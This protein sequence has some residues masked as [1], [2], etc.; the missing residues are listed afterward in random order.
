MKQPIVTIKGVTGAL[1]FVKT[2]DFYGTISVTLHMP[3]G[4]HAEFSR[5]TWAD[6]DWAAEAE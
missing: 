2:N 1:G 4:A 3:D 6:V 5:I